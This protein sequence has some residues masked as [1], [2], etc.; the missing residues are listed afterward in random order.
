MAERQE[1]RAAKDFGRADEIRDRL[2][3]LGWEVRDS[4]DGPAARAEG[5]MAI[6]DHLRA[7][8]G[9][10]GGTG[11]AAGP[12]GLAGAGD[13]ARGAGAALRLARP[14]G[15]RRRGRS[16]SRTRTRAGCCAA[17]NALIVALD[18][19]Q[20]PRNLGRRLPL[21]RGRRRGRRGVPGAALGRGHR[22]HLQGLGG[23][24]RAP[25]RSPTSATSPTGWR[26]PRQAGFWIWGAD[27][28]GEAAALGRR[29]RAAPPSSS[30]A[31]RARASGPGSRRRA[32]ACVALPRRGEVESLNVS[33]AATALLFESRS[34]ARLSRALCFST[35]CNGGCKKSP[36]GVDRTPRS[37]KLA[38]PIRVNLSLSLRMLP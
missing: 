24:G 21:G 38:P 9:R 30:S 5:L 15:C 3:E 37:R 6:A 20:D 13:V 23:R 25:R 33:A 7:P 12:A 22:R 8:A 4:A 16:L 14:P 27:A 2:A 34:P 32:T 31:A 29:P 19:V 28:D 17:T 18:Q 11:E 36:S 1:A 10:R 26:R 35:A